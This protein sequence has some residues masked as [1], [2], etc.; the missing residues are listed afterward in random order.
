[1]PPHLLHALKPGIY[2]ER[3]F[4]LAFKIPRLFDSRQC[5]IIARAT[6]L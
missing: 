3:P 1:M 5:N 6:R 4:T 2:G